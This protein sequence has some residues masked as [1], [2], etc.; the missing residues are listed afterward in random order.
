MS[1]LT[2]AE[3]SMRAKLGAHAQWARTEDR[4]ART[5]SARAGFHRRFENAVDPD[6]LLDPEERHRRAQHARKAYMLRLAMASAKARRL[7]TQAGG[8]A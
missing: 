2:P 4:T 3:R 7:R 6:G 8:G 1:S 5:A